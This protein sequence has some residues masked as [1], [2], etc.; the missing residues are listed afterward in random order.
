MDLKEAK[1]LCLIK[2]QIIIDNDGKEDKVLLAQ[3]KEL[4][5][6]RQHHWCAL[7]LL[8][9]GECSDCELEIDNP[10]AEYE[11]YIN[12]TDWHHPYNTWEDCQIKEHAEEVYKLI[13]E[14]KL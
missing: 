11:S 12:C 9:D 1:R 13:E 2:W 3:N 6:T 14:I 10:N 5:I 4:E 7:C 8:H